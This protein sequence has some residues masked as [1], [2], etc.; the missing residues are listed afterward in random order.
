MLPS[1]PLQHALQCCEDALTL[2]NMENCGDCSTR[3]E[4]GYS[5]DKYG[6]LMILKLYYKYILY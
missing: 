6:G 2:G 3:L 4:R 5:I 1:Q